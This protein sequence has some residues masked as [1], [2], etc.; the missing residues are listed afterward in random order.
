M[1]DSLEDFSRSDLPHCL[2][3]APLAPLH[4]CGSLNLVLVSPHGGGTSPVLPRLLAA[5]VLTQVVKVGSK[6]LV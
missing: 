2:C 5:V 1:L 3:E 6:H 4:V